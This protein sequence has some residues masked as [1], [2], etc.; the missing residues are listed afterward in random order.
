MIKIELLNKRLL[1]ISVIGG[2][3]LSLVNNILYRIGI[4]NSF[5]KLSVLFPILLMS[6]IG[7]NNHIKKLKESDKSLNSYITFILFTFIQWLI[8]YIYWMSLGLIFS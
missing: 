4:D 6:I 3:F 8:L 2:L 1:S 7:Q 5:D